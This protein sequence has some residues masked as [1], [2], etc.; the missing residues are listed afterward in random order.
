MSVLLKFLAA[1]D[2][3]SAII[4]ITQ[5]FSFPILPILFTVVLL[6]KGVMSLAADLSSKIYGTVDIIAALMLLSHAVLFP[7]NIVVV[8]ILIYKGI[9]SLV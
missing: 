1:T 3:L 4:I 9:F 5:A 8:I 7:L 6:I 2:F